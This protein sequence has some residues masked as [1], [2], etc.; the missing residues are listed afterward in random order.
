VKENAIVQRGLQW[1]GE[2]KEIRDS[3]SLGRG[4][5]LNTINPSCPDVHLQD[6]SKD[7]EGLRGYYRFSIALP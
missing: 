4:W 7:H 2:W 6:V 1:G 5:G 3:P